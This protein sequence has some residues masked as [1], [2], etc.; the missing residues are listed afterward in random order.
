[1]IRLGR[2][3]PHRW[4]WAARAAA[5]AG[6]L[7]GL[8]LAGPGISAVADTAPVP[9]LSDSTPPT[10]VPPPQ[11]SIWQ[12]TWSGELS[13][14]SYRRSFGQLRNADVWQGC[15]IPELPTYDPGAV[16]PMPFRARILYVTDE[17]ICHFNDRNY[18][19]WVFAGNN[20]E[21]YELRTGLT[22]GSD[23]PYCATVE[24]AGRNAQDGDVV[25]LLRCSG[26][27]SQKWTLE[28]DHN[29]R[30]II[31]SR[32]VADGEVKVLD[33]PFGEPAANGGG[34][35]VW[36]YTGA[37]NQRWN[38]SMWSFKGD[39]YVGPGIGFPDDVPLID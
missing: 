22:S 23:T 29:D 17:W 28:R 3:S 27:A 4:K 25:T 39:D 18:S 16:F 1:M 9:E 10:L 36:S 14:A 31:K 33:A 26:T 12:H 30:L 20:D 7:A 37:N 11:V 15:W 6:A 34:V 19:D 2:R 8:T 24:P 5:L 38:Y 35:H 13:Y 32:A 21:G